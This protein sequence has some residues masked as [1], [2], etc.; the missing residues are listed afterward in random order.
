M[1]KVFG[2]LRWLGRSPLTIVE[3]IV[4]IATVISGVYV[5]TPLIDYSTYL[6]GATPLVATLGSAL[7]IHIFGAF[8]LLSGLL[9]IYGIFKRNYRAR[10]VGLFMNILG[11]TYILLAG[12]LIQG[13]LPFTWLN[14]FVMILI[15]T[16]CWLVVKGMIVRENE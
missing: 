2:N 16:I 5:L 6:H 8:Y 4:G 15:V 9:I 11:R 3:L 10:S 7:G 12:F 1:K 14:P 13:F